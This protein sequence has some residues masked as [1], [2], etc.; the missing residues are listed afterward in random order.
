MVSARF[1]SQGQKWRGIGRFARDIWADWLHVSTLAV[2]APARGHGFGKQLMKR[3]GLYAVKRR[4]S[5]DSKSFDRAIEEDGT[6]IELAKLTEGP[7][8]P[9]P[10]ISSLKLRSVS[11]FMTKQ[12]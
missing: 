5:A 10:T 1:L 9:A 7:A 11:T 2:A 12:V 8:G 6:R 3:A 4:N